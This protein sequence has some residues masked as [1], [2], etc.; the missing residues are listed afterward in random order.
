MARKTLG[1]K[2]KKQI[3]AKPTDE[4]EDQFPNDPEKRFLNGVAIHPSPR[5]Y[6]EPGSKQRT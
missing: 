6:L 3:D 5:I 1:L 4:V 2:A